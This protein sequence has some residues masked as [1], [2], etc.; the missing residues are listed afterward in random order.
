MKKEH[1]KH[2]KNKYLRIGVLL[3]LAI[4]LICSFVS[5]NSTSDG[6][7]DATADATEDV[8]TVMAVRLTED[9]ALGSKIVAA[10][11]EVVELDAD[12]ACIGAIDDVN[13]I[14]GKYATKDLEAGEFV[15]ASHLSVDKVAVSK[16]RTEL[17]NNGFGFYGQGYVVV[18][19]YVTPNQGN[20]L[21]AELQ[22]IINKN[23]TTNKVIYFPDGEYI[24]SK[25]LHTSSLGTQS[26]SLKLSD[27]A[28]IKAASN[29]DKS[30]GAMIQ[31]GAKDKINNIT[32]LGSN[33]FFDGGIIDGSGRAN[34]I[35]L[36]GGRETCIRNVKVIN[37]YI[38]IHWNKYG[39][40]ADSEARDITIVGNGAPGSIGLRIEG[41]DSTFTNMRISN[42]QTGVY[43]LSPAHILRN[44]QVTYV[45]NPMLNASYAA[46]Y[47]FRS[48]D[49]RCWFD[50]CRSEGFGTAFSI[51]NKDVLNSCV[52][53]WD[54]VYGRQVAIN[55]RAQN[56]T[57]VARG[58]IAEFTAP[59]S[60]CEYLL[61]KSGCSGA[62]Y[63]PIFDE[64]AVNSTVYK[65]YL[66]SSTKNKE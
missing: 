33:Y 26:V 65:E 57:G 36:D 62:I 58:V 16:G 54:T 29:W 22:A 41:S 13:A 4:V 56:F 21:S 7:T 6:A 52:A 42:V 18:T 5:C 37:T 8:K 17:E 2:R 30:Q 59:K 38:G 53:T 19:E 11:L 23:S 60:E 34:G 10:K 51:S 31:L 25:P 50:T 27:N 14:V 12:K 40:V 44:I 55:G 45:S 24:I 35:S 20:D 49:H 66:R 61:A 9:V 3:C 1:Q 32:I 28:V 15:L 63:D 39:D 46:S 43:I 47:G 64:N 48:E